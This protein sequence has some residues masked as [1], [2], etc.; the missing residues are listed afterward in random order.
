[1]LRTSIREKEDLSRE[2]E[3]R[4]KQLEEDYEAKLRNAFEQ[5]EKE[6]DQLREKME[7]II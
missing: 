4:I 3:D 2:Y 1:M 6:L 5:K 7:T